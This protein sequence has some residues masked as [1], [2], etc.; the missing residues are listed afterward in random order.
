MVKRCVD[1]YPTIVN[2][3]KESGI[4][5]NN[6]KADYAKMDST[7]AKS[8][9]G[10]GESSNIAQLAITYAWTEINSVR[11]DGDRILALEEVSTIMAVIAQ[12]LID[13][14]K[15]LY[16]VDGMAEVKRI[17]KLPCMQMV[18]PDPFDPEHICRKDFPEFFNYVRTVPVM[19]Y[20]KPRPTN[21]IRCDQARIRSR[22]NYRL[23]CPMNIVCHALDEVPDA[24]RTDTEDIKDYFIKIP[25]RVN[26]RQVSKIALLADEL[27][28]YIFVNVDNDIY[29][30]LVRERINDIVDRLQRMK[31]QNVATI[32]RLIEIALKI[33][34]GRTTRYNT[35]EV[36]QNGRLILMLLYKANPKKF[37][38]SFLKKC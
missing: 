8:Q 18:E 26:N 5:Y 32:N 31:I 17:A 30:N 16:E 7:F 21:D 11:P 12:V 22:V 35:E 15:R 34:D 3:L 24:P 33:S 38:Q 25:G 37:L 29:T 20:G 9:M 28:K 14:C 6:T 23:I 36:R 10:I 4:T 27:R 2:E 1:N 13:S 19:K